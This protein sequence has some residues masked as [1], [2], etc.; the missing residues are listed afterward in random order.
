[1]QIHVNYSTSILVFLQRVNPSKHLVTNKIFFLS[2]KMATETMK[3]WT[4]GTV[5][6]TVP[7]LPNVAEGL[8]VNDLQEVTQW[9]N[10][11]LTWPEFP[12]KAHRKMLDFTHI[13]WENPLWGCWIQEYLVEFGRF[14]LQMTPLSLTRLKR[15]STWSPVPCKAEDFLSSCEPNDSRPP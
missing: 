5:S 15:K 12:W 9:P 10:H 8:V 4:V 3:T 2:I 7:R 6:W 14:I 1:M 11:H 13:I